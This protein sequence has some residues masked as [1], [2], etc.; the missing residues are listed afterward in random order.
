MKALS[1]QA[2]SEL[3]GRI[4]DPSVRD[5][6]HFILGAM[7]SFN[8]FEL[9]PNIQGV[10]KS[11][12]FARGGNSAYAFIA[13][14]TW[15]LWYFRKPGFTSGMF[16]W[17]ELHEMFPAMKASE[18]SDPMK[19]EGTFRIASLSDAEDVIRFVRRKL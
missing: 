15:L 12:H 9:Q 7:I 6:F 16:D 10:K 19:A 14:N 3:L 5:A 4:V 13:N 17:P 18:R 8:C 1:D 2:Y 11:I